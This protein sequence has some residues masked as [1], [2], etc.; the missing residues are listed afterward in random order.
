MTPFFGFPGLSVVVHGFIVLGRKLYDAYC[1][2]K[3]RVS[4][5]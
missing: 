5:A 1:A 3:R 4:V 2:R